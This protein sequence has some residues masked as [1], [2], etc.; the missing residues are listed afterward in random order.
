MLC[1]ILLSFADLHCK[2]IRIENSGRVYHR[3]FQEGQCL[4]LVVFFVFF[5]SGIKGVDLLKGK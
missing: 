2:T 5:P 3:H 4:N 1:K